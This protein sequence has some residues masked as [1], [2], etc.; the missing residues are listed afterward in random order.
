MSEKSSKPAYGVRACLGYMLRTARREALGAPVYAVV[1]ALLAFA[2]S[3]VQLFG[4]PLILADVESRAP[5]AHLAILILAFAAALTLLAGL[6]RYATD[7][8]LYSRV[9]VR[10]G[11]MMDLARKSTST[12]YSNT[13]DPRFKVL[14]STCQQ[15][16]NS[17][18]KSTE[19]IWVTLQ[20]LLTDLLGFGAY[21]LLLRAVDPLLLAVVLV[22]S[23]LSFGFSMFYQRWYERHREAWDKADAR[24]NYLDSKTRPFA[25]DMRIFGFTGWFREMQE[26]A[27]HVVLLA[28][29][30]IANKQII[31]A[32]LD[33]LLSVLRLGAAYGLLL[34][35]ALREGLPASQF[36][37]Y[38]SAVTGLATWISGILSQVSQVHRECLEISKV[39]EFL[40][41]P[42][43]FNLGTGKPISFT[44]A[45]SFTFDHVSF[46]YPGSE[47]DTIHDLNLTIAP[48]ERVAVVGLNGAGKTTLIKLLAGFLDPTQGRVLLNGTD[49]R[50]FDREQYYELFSAVFQESSKLYVTVAQNVAQR[51]EGIDRARVARCLEQADLTRLV[52]KLPQ[53]MDTQVGRAIYLDGT[54]FSGGETQRLMLARALYKDG[55][56][57]LLDE[58]TAALDPLAESDLYQKYSD[59]TRGKTSVFISHRLASTRFCDRIL[60]LEQGRIAEQGTHE[61]LLQKGGGYAEL[62][63]VQSRYYQE[64]RDF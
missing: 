35:M 34:A 10:F 36:L 54:L 24:I 44:K 57:L 20:E 13:L 31:V 15:A 60:F 45:Y 23:I 25:K 39:L 26:K 55:P 59:M 61:E 9:A 40:H 50:E 33:L 16:T 27:Y 1:L 62:F 29:L 56:V 64:G 21:L 63:H 11:I 4:P 6:N 7:T 17:N 46:R 48:G 47:E 3:L 28:Q 43:P 37:L 19:H 2:Q 12:S 5:A 52:E 32:A 41:F 38:F 53:G 30:K 22:T 14:L 51:I 58:P 49:I 18:Q 8:S 42:E